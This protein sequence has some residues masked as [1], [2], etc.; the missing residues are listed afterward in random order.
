MSRI[1]VVFGTTD[2]HTAKIAK[3]VGETLTS[4][5][6]QVDVARAAPGGR[7]PD[8]A[9]YDGIIVAA[10][11]HAGGYQPPIGQWVRRH[12]AD[13]LGRP[14]AMLSVCLG[15]LEQNPRVWADLD[16]KIDRFLTRVGW[17]PTVVKIVAGAI[18]YS[19][20]GWLKRLVMQHMTRKAGVV[21][22]PS[23][24]YE[25]TDWED[26]RLFTTGFLRRMTAGTPEPSCCDLG[27]CRPH[28]APT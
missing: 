27:V 12:G 23:R 5:G 11:L 17:R 8:G 9:D 15:I 1:L 14:T 19:R 4:A 18:P 2:G 10:S 28:G 24:D 21:T 16:A 22:D 20:Y 26:L 25:Y 13:L 7:S 6:S 3:F